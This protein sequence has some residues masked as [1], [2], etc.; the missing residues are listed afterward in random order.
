MTQ[1]Q[2]AVVLITGAA[3]GFGQELTRQLLKIGSRLI[4]T[5]RD[6][7]GLQQQAEILWKEAAAGEILACLEADLASR[8]GCELLYQQVRS[9]NVPVDVLINNAG[10]AVFGRTDE[11]PIDQWEQLMQ[12]NLLTPMRL[13]SWFLAEMIDR[14]KGHIVNISSM[15][16]W[17]SR[18]GLSHYVASKFGLRGFSETLFDEAKEHQVKVTT[19]YPFFSRTPILQCAQHGTLA[20]QNNALPDRLITN[21]VAVMRQTIQAIQQDK[22]EVFPDRIGHNIH[23]MKRYFPRFLDWISDRML[24]PQRKL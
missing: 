1:L 14:Q 8:E 18:A 24:K 11:V 5:D 19:V 10:I 4:L 17:T 2:N 6:K 7:T 12:V 20:Q 13:S 3:G 23:L 21:P 9:L 22:R 16:G 15:A